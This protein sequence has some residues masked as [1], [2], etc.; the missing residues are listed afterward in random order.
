[1]EAEIAEVKGLLTS[2]RAALEACTDI[3]E[4]KM[5]RNGLHDLSAEKQRLDDR[6]NCLINEKFSHPGI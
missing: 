4:K 6:L 3:E 1:M 5:I 2:E